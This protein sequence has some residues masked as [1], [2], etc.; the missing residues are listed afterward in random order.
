MR[1]GEQAAKDAVVAEL[2]S[3]VELLDSKVKEA[4]R[5]RARVWSNDV[6]LLSE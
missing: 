2:A 3:E 5:I 6:I 4:D 1:D